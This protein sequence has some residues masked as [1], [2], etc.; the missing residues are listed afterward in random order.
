MSGSI[1]QY[2]NMGIRYPWVTDYLNKKDDFWDDNSLGS[3]MVKSLRSFLRHAQVIDKNGVTTFGE[4]ISVMGGNSE[5]GWALMLCNLVYTPQFNWWALNVQFNKQY[6]QFELDEILKDYVS[7]NYSRKNIISGFKSIFFT[8]PVLSER[9]GFGV[10]N[11]KTKGNNTYLEAAYRKSW[12]PPDPRVILYSLYK[13]AEACG[14]MHQFS[15][16]TLL[17][18]SIERDGVSPTRIFGLDKE[19]MIPLL[20]GL[21]ANYPNFIS[22]SFTLGLDSIT[23]RPDKKSED[24]LDLF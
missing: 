5:I 23:L 20:N 15:L 22:V 17:D 16:E 9:I 21:S 7:S 14:D 10:V 8:N 24:V 1:D 2:K 13:F 18:D 4:K 11:V 19:T 6:S 12:Q 3:E